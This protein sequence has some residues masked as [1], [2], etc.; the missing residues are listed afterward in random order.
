MQDISQLHIGFASEWLKY[1]PRTWSGTPYSLWNAL[2]HELVHPIYDLDAS[3]PD[4]RLYAHKI[5]TGRVHEGKLISKYRHTHLHL[6]P[7]EK[8]LHRLIAALPKKLDA[9]LTIGDIGTTNGKYPFYI[10]L[11]MTID[12]VMENYGKFPPG[13]NMFS[14]YSYKN[15]LRRKTWQ[16]RV[17][18]ECAGIFSMSKMMANHIINHSG[19]EAGKVH[20]VHAGNNMLKEHDEAIGVKDV[21]VPLPDRKKRVLFVG[22]DFLRKGGDLVLQAFEYLVREYKSDIR[23]TIIGPLRWPQPGSIPHYVDFVGD[24]PYDQVRSYYQQADLFCLPSR[25]EGF[26]LVFTEA[27]SY[28]VPCIGRRA[29]AMPEIISHGVDGYLIEKDDPVELASLIVRTLEDDAMQARVKN[30]ASQYRQYYSWNRV[31][32]DILTVIGRDTQ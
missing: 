14:F 31:A 4:I 18:R 9:I 26:G 12:Y 32:R 5:L 17:F 29:F 11:D 16:D 6:R 22:R 25:Y 3:L 8:K 13:E 10:Y 20:V 19:V 27:L 28:G 23:L 1:R 24:I 15:L 2:Q 30:N 21:V 7:V